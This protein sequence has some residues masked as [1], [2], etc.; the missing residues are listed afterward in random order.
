MTLTSP[1]QTEITA[2]VQLCNT[3]EP[4]QFR[5]G[6]VGREYPDQ[7]EVRLINKDEVGRGELF[8]MI[9]ESEY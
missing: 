9:S 6:R 8:L 3:P 7:C 5:I 1:C 2:F 4:G